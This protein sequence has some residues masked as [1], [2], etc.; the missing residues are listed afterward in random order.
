LEGSLPWLETD[1]NLN[2]I[3][4]FHTVKEMKKKATPETLCNTSDSSQLKAFVTEIF[5]L[6]FADTP[7]YQKLKFMLVKSLLELNDTPNGVF[8]WNLQFQ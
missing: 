1:E 4:E 7:D 2:D 6:Q 3:E 5:K 8:D